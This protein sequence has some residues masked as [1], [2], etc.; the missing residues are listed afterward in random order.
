MS[1]AGKGRRRRGLTAE[2]RALWARVTSTASPLHP[3]RPAPI[4]ASA[5]AAAPVERP[6]RR[7]TRSGHSPDESPT[8]SGQRRDARPDKSPTSSVRLPDASPTPSARPATT[9][10]HARSPFDRLDPAAGLDRRTAD[11]LRRGKRDPEARLDL[12][13][14]TASA[15][16]AALSGFLRRARAEGK[17]CVLV[18]TGKGGRKPV[19]DAPYMPER[20]GVL[21]Y[22]VP[23]WLSTAPLSPLVVGVYKAHRSHGGDGAL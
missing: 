16:H 11:R 12:H 9:V 8:A 19:E 13:G 20:T 7:G 3:V 1:S 10:R 5:P 4:S 15:A 6:D 2:D 22:A 14:M 23:E 18:I 17:R 21:R